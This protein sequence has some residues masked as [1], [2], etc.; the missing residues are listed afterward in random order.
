MFYLSDDGDIGY[1][2]CIGAG[3]TFDS[4]D[5]LLAVMRA[6]EFGKDDATELYNSFAGTVGFTDV[7]PWKATCKNVPYAAAAIWKAIQRFNNESEGYIATPIP[8]SEFGLSEAS[9]PIITVTSVDGGG[10]VTGISKP[11]GTIVAA[12]DGD[13]ADYEVGPKAPEESETMKKTTK[14]KGLAAK[15]QDAL[16]KPAKKAAKGP[17]TGK[18]APKSLKAGK[19]TRKAAGA[20]TGKHRDGTKRTQVLSMIG[21][22]DGASVEELMGAFGWKRHSVRGYLSTLGSQGV[23]FTT[24][25]DDKRG[26]VYKAA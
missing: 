7:K 22:K 6:R 25:R 21:R 8:S 10:A 26:H 9:G 14:R 24:E 2:E 5:G 17:K 23:K 18:A 4:Q 13:N 11:D 16:A 20:S 19:T 3:D 15:V 12:L 1:G